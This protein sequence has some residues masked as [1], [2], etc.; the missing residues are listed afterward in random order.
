MASDEFKRRSGGRALPLAWQ[1]NHNPDNAFW[2]LGQRPGFLRLTTG[3]VDADFLSA[4]NTLTQ[5]TFGP[6]CSGTVA[7]DAS[8]MKDGD[9]AGLSALQKKY[10]LVGVSMSGQTKSLVMM[11]AQSDVPVEVE[12]VPLAQNK[13]FLKIECDY[14]NGADKATFFYSLDNKEWKAIG[15]PLQMVYTLPHF[16]GY[17]FGLF[18]YATKSAGGWADFDY[19]RVSAETN[20]EMAGK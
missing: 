2:S 7:L 10:G 13:V 9:F 18:N 11:S 17:R 6:Q 15:A 8:A 4:R 12:R 1:W 16:M 14:K 19:F 3:R 20:G 5:R